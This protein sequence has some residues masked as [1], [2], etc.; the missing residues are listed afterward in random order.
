MRSRGKKYAKEVVVTKS[1]TLLKRAFGTTFR[2]GGFV[3]V[4]EKLKC[5]PMF[6]K[7]TCYIRVEKD[8]GVEGY[9]NK[10]DIKIITP[11]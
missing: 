8:N 4:G 7:E 3:T 10:R 2:E 11:C 1:Q 6:G 9:I 5:L